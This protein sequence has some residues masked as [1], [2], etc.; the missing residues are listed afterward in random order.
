MLQK[1]ELMDMQAALALSATNKA[2]VVR[3]IRTVVIE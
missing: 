2:K 3:D 1:L